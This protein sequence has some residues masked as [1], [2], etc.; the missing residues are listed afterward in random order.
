MATYLMFGKYTPEALT[1]VSAKRTEDA[2]ALI[3]SLGGSVHAGYALLGANDLVLIVDLPD[4]Q[5][6][7]KASAALTK[8]TGIGFTTAPAV[9][10]D[11]FDK[12]MA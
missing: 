4:T 5:R 10:I 11:E 6:A 8:L 9:T 7:M 3:K 2:T 12:L 1:G